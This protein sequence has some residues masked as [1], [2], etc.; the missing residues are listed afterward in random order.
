VQVEVPVTRVH[1]GDDRRAVARLG[2]VRWSSWTAS[3]T[4]DSTSLGLLVRI[5]VPPRRVPARL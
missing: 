5:A 3:L 2:G 1:N 4:A